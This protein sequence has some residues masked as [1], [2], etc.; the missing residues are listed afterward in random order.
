MTVY[1]CVCVFVGIAFA[2]PGWCV[3]VTVY[4]CVFVEIAFAQPGWLSDTNQNSNYR[5]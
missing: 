4:A 5:R 1:V 2:Q 3:C